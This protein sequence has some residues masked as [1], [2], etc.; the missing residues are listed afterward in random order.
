[1]AEA[2]LRAR[3]AGRL[4]GV[5]VA[6]AGIAAV[7]GAPPD[8]AALELMAGRG[9]DIGAHRGVQLDLELGAQFDLHLVMESAQRDFIERRWPTLTGR[10]HELG[11]WDGGDIADPY[12]QGRAA[13]ETA[14]AAIDRGIELWLP[15]LVALA[16]DREQAPR[17]GG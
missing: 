10:V 15:R 8:P 11:C 12:R 6:S 5:T 4:P 7:V 17:A 2:V 14:L 13:F 16:A 1:M 3:F 9:L